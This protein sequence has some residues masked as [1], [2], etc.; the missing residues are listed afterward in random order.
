MVEIEREST[1]TWC[2]SDKQ[3]SGLK[4]HIRVRLLAVSVLWLRGV[5]FQ[6]GSYSE[7]DSV[8]DLYMH[9]TNKSLTNSKR[10]IKIRST[11]VVQEGNEVRPILSLVIT[12]V[13]SPRHFS[14]CELA[15]RR[16]ASGRS[17]TGTTWGCEFEDDFI[18]KLN[19]NFT[20]KKFSS[21]EF[22]KVEFS[23]YLHSLEYFPTNRFLTYSSTVHV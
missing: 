21:Y 20:F 15:T 7:V 1:H 2:C 3:N 14:P 19:A 4:F 10:V 17:R 18:S 11:A 23:F 16:M 13:G 8:K 22:F 5:H 6:A 9:K 12:W